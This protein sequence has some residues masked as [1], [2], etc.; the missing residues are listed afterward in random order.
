MHFRLGTTSSVEDTIP[1]VARKHRLSFR[2]REALAGY[3]F[4]APVV[5]GLLIFTLVP[6]LSALYYSF[7]D[8]DLLT[9]ANWV[10]LANYQELWHD[11][12]WFKSLL[13]TLSYALISVPLGLIGS[14]GLALLLNRDVVGARLWRAI[15]Y[16]PV[17][18]PVVAGA[19]IWANMFNPQ[20]GLLNFIL[21]HLHL[22]PYT[23]LQEPES[24]L[25]S[26]IVMSLWGIGGPM[27]IWIS[28]LR[29]VPEQLYEAAK[30]DGANT[31]QQFY[32]VTLPMLSPVIFFN[33]IIGVIGSLQLFA[34]AQVITE[35][36]PQ[37]IAGGPLHSTFFIVIYIYQEAF[38]NFRMGYAS[39]IAWM[40][41]LLIGG[42]TLLLFRTSGW[43]YYE[44][45]DRS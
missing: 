22:P 6:L 11:P 13:V 21:V 5:L 29:S 34:Q 7:T 42:L 40:L 8:Y 3:L 28:G 17:I 44:G 15:F 18:F 14:L 33:A 43:V 30:I 23:W 10:G 12:L 20:D 1:V 2:G 27:L 9:Q 38:Q 26:L 24:A 39:A 37:H 31:W 36:G 41:F 19:L 35:N 25:P 16:L 45:G 32:K 4:V